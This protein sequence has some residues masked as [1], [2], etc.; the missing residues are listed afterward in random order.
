MRPLPIRWR[1]TAWYTASFACILVLLGA[2]LFF[3]LRA[4]L[5]ATFDDQLRAQA[6]TTLS[7]VQ[8]VGG[9]LTLSTNENSDPQSGEHFV[10]LMTA[11][12]AVVADT[13]SALGSIPLDPALVAAAQAGETGVVSLAFEGETLRVITV[14]VWSNGAV[15][16]ILQVGMLRGDID[17][18]LADLLLGLGIVMPILLIVAAGGSYL[19]VGRSLSPVAAMTEQAASIGNGDLQSRLNLDL[20][21]DELGHLAQTLDAMLDRIEEAFAR[22]RRFT[23]DAAH[24]LRTP[25]STM[26]GQISLGL[27]RPR[28]VDDYQVILR[29]V[30]GDLLRLN[31]VVGALLTLARSDAGLAIERVPFDLADTMSLVL[32]QYAGIAQDAGIALHDETAPA[33]LDGDEDLLIQL[34]TNLLDNA[35]AHTPT[36]GTIT[37]GC[38]QDGSSI[39]AWVEDT[40]EGIAPEHQAR[41][42]DRF[43]RVD[44]G[45]TRT[46]GGAGLGLSICQ[47]IVEAHGGTITLTSSTSHGTSVE[48]RLPGSNHHRSSSL[49]PF[50][51]GG[52]N[53]LIAPIE[54]KTR[55]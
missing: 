39:R 42:F 40:G 34:L 5:H 23:G 41:I 24:E 3:G 11:S 9:S 36:G 32:E 50:R 21:K 54:D 35:L 44:T 26:L 20:P 12:G 37:V 46:Q 14:P 17:R 27:A 49:T 10:R 45:R 2:G 4:R 15:V 22:Q 1:L 31:E 6:S 30:E 29:D 13:S 8:S 48:A 16:G 25:I 53:I 55:L 47:A 7:T 38:R 51:V 18:A 33:P 43:Y 28:S 19:L 52:K